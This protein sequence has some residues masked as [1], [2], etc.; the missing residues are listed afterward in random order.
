MTET[1]GDRIRQRRHRRKWTAEELA[2]RVG[3]HKTTVLRY[4]SGIYSPRYVELEAL[5]RALGC[6]VRHLVPRKGER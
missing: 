1:V 5:A 3:L 6:E 4:E 2:R